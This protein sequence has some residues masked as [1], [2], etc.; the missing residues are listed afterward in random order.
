LPPSLNVCVLYE[1]K[2]CHVPQDGNPIDLDLSSSVDKDICLVNHVPA[3]VQASTESISTVR[4][5]F[6]GVKFPGSE[7]DHRDPS[8]TAVTNVWRYTVF[9][10][11]LHYLDFEDNGR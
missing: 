10:G 6:L 9:P 4:E 8:S 5:A 2:W 11:G 1:K 3:S 7:T